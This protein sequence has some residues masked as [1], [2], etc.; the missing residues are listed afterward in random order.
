[1]LAC[2]YVSVCISACVCMYKCVHVVW[3]VCEYVCASVY[4]CLCV[5][6]RVWCG[7]GVGGWEMGMH[8]CVH[9][10]RTCVGTYV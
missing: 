6:T 2:V 4:V 8:A 10:V 1:M 3:C 5:C 7:V 9:T